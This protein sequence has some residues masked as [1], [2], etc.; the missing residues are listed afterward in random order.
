MLY[1][2]C[3]INFVTYLDTF[4]VDYEEKFVSGVFFHSSD[5]KVL[6]LPISGVMHWH[7]ILLAELFH[8]DYIDGVAGHRSHMVHPHEES[9]LVVEGTQMGY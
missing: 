5:L 4:R 8:G 9:R 3:D 6:L 7:D 2:V 1:K